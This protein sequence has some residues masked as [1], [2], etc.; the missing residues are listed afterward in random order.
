MD[1]ASQHRALP[2]GGDETILLVEDDEPVREMGESQ[3]VS[4][5]YQVVSAANGVDALSRHADNPNVRILV[6]DVVMPDMGGRELARRLRAL[7]PQL[8]VLFTSGYTFD[9]I[10]HADL[11]EAGTRFLQKPYTSSQLA[12][13][14]RELLDAAPEASINR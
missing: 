3:L 1:S 10:E 13:V 4:F 5:G 2:R 6:T 7:R 9:A 8:K 14:I 12:A 11:L